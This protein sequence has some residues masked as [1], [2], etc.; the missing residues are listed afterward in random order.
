MSDRKKFIKHMSPEQK[1]KAMLRMAKKKNEDLL[2]KYLGEAKSTSQIIGDIQKRGK[3]I[4]DDPFDIN[5]AYFELDGT[6]W[7]AGIGM[8]SNMGN[9]ND[10]VKKV[11]SGKLRAK[12]K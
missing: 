5:K 10:F 12:L 3:R 1:K 8:V 7:K 2:V 9:V 6:V 4:A 11:K